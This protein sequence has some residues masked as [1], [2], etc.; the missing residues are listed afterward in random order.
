MKRSNASSPRSFLRLVL[1]ILIVS[2]SVAFA[3]DDELAL[4]AGAGA[5]EAAPVEGGAATADD[6]EL[7]AMLN[8][9]E[10]DPTDLPTKTEQARRDTASPGD[11][12]LDF[13][14]EKPGEAED[15]YAIPQGGGRVPQFEDPR[16]ETESIEV[17]RFHRKLIS[18][19]EKYRDPG[20]DDAP[21]TFH[22]GFGPALFT[23]AD[24][25]AQLDFQFAFTRNFSLG[26]VGNF[27]RISNQASLFGQ[28]TNGS[29]SVL[30]VGAALNFYSRQPYEG[31]WIQAG[32]GY[33]TFRDTTSSLQGQIPIFFSFG[34]RFLENRHN[35]TFAFGAGSHAY[36]FNSQPKVFLTL[37]LEIGFGWNVFPY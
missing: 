14:S 29:V 18:E 31:I 24:Y 16:E 3:E 27:A 32:S 1:V 6:A 28:T 35:L 22:F 21:L 12:V 5:G 30:G 9:R 17:L 15:V 2:G 4:D 19:R 7:E 25:G 33:D 13:D 36:F 26:L 8:A 11:D 20:E 10:G 34:W 23:E 37:K